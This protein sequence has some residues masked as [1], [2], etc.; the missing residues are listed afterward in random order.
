MGEHKLSAL[1]RGLSPFFF[2]KSTNNT[3]GGSIY[4]DTASEYDIGSVDKPFANIYADN[5][6]SSGGSPLD[7]FVSVNSS[8]ATSGYLDDKLTVNSPITKSI[9]SSVIHIGI[10]TSGFLLAD[11]SHA[12]TGN[13]SVNSGV[14]IDGVDI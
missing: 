14:T 13:L 8:D 5:L 9:T 1:V 6:L 2:N 11:G 7:K 10:D 3:I 4:A 12:L